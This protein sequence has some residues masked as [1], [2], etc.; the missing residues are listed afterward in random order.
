M[1]I[2]GL[3]SGTSADGIDAVLCEIAGHRYELSVQFIA[4]HQ[5]LY[6]V[7]TRA[8]ILDA[9]H[10]TLSTVERLC[11]LNFVLGEKFAEAAQAV[12]A[13]AAVS[14]DS[15]ELIG[16]HGQ[17]VWHD[18][19]ANGAVTSTLQI[20]EPAV[21]AE[22]TDVPT[23]A[24]FRVADVAAGGQGAPLVPFADFIL[25]RQLEKYRA[26]QNIGGIAN[27]TL[28]PP[29]CQPNEVI[30]FDSGPGN[31]II[32][33]LVERTTDGRE[34]FDREGRIAA[35]GDVDG[36]WLEELLDHPYYQRTPP[37]TTGR[38]LFGKPY[39]DEF[40]ETGIARGLK[41]QDIVATATALTAETIAMA[42][43]QK[44]PAELILGGGGANNQTLVKLLAMRLPHTKILRHEDFGIPTQAKEA[45]AFAILAYAA[46]HHE[47]NNLPSVTGAR[48]SVVMGKLSQP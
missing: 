48:R 35:S 20:G 11:R 47:P 18:V 41:P 22:R 39:A 40:W 44:H 28:L 2:I 6:D 31:M 12:C 27:V 1:R 10:P 13:V 46:Y 16:S 38:E 17:T 32:D 4:H 9:C 8:A 36:A 30:A 23:I 7:A 19:A 14:L 33:A 34:T 3:M 45:L 29:H 26:I 43:A 37:K 21:I 15:V 5:T 24:D 25:F 42:F